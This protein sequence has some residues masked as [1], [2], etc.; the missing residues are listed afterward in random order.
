MFRSVDPDPVLFHLKGTPSEK[1]TTALWIRVE[2]R[3]NNSNN[4]H[5]SFSLDVLSALA[6]I[7]V[8]MSRKHVRVQQLCLAICSLNF[9]NKVGMPG[10]NEYCVM[11]H[12]FCAL[13]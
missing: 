12:A 11:I 4:T 5:G 10:K 8:L 1:D 9:M 13:H 2:Q 3:N 6:E 7:N